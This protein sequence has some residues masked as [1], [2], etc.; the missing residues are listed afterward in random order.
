MIDD[1]SL[2]D[3]PTFKYIHARRDKN[4]TSRP[5]PCVNYDRSKA[6]PIPHPPSAA[7]RLATASVV[8]IFRGPHTHALEILG[9]LCVLLLKFLLLVQRQFSL[10]AVEEFLNL[11]VVAWIFKFAT[12]HVLCSLWPIDA[13]VCTC[14]LR[15]LGEGG[16]W[17]SLPSHSSVS[18]P[19]WSIIN[20]YGRIKMQK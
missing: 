14:T 17:L 5:H 6:N 8:R 9:A 18:P 13:F 3:A 20:F 11:N 2:K 16:C 15:L 7:L 10:Q 1:G 4:G 19:P 12:S